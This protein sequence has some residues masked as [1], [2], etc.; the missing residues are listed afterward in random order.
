[1]RPIDYHRVITKL[2]RNLDLLKHHH[3]TVQI[4]SIRRAIETR[5][6]HNR[7]KLRILTNITKT[8]PAEAGRKTLDKEVQRAVR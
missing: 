8:Q 3:E 5:L 4:R 7:L 6:A 1:M 2:Q